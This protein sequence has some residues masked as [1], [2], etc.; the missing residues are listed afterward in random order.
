M[1]HKIAI[2]IPIKNN[3]KKL[4]DTFL[5][6]TY[7][8]SFQKT[9]SR[10]LK[11]TFY[12]GL[13]EGDMMLEYNNKVR[14]IKIIEEMNCKCKIIKFDSTI[15]KGHV[16]KMWNILFNIAYNEDN[17]YFYQCGDDIELITKDWA[18]DFINKLKKHKDFGV[19]GPKSVNGHQQILTQTF[20]SKKHFKIFNFY[21]P[22]AIKNWFCDNW[23]STVYRINNLFFML[24]NHRIKNKGGKPRYNVITNSL[25]ITKLLEPGSILIY[26]YI[27]ESNEKNKH[28]IIKQDSFNEL[29]K[30]INYLI[31]QFN[32]KYKN[33]YS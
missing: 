20:V 4:E 30:T 26:N 16:T 2:L 6:N 25:W 17:D 15:Q 23:I 32:T 1:S 29:K 22:N 5:F 9:M 13:D 8:P 12:I 27:K 7:L 28:E 21:F 18:I 24:T 11:Y 33:T 10:E 3:C 19:V 14:I 31:Y